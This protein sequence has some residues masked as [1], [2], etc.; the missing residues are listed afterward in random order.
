MKN[1]IIPI[2]LGVFLFPSC[3]NDES[4][5]PVEE[6]T[7]DSIYVLE[8]N[9]GQSTLGIIEIDNFTSGANYLTTTNGNDFAHSSGLYEPSF[10][11]P[12]ILS[13]YGNH[14][15]TGAYGTAELQISRPTYSIH[16]VMETECITV[17]GNTAMYGA[18]I[19]EVIE[20]SGNTPPLT[21]MWR[22]Y[23][24]VKDK[25]PSLRNG[26]DQ[27]SNK[28][29]FASPRSVSLCSIY[30]PNHPI[31]SSNGQADVLSP[32]FVEVSNNP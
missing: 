4:F 7:T 21:D 6:Q 20:L 18:I 32:G 9:M 8:Q 3:S 14:D 13:W 1:L 24:Q 22:F 23:F 30:P 29:I 26:V 11:D 2:A 28:W 12:V 27:I 5:E 31:W 10:R 19:T 15:N 17:N 25:T 16:V